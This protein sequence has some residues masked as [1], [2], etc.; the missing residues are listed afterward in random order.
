MQCNAMQFFR[1]HNF[2]HAFETCQIGFAC[3]MGFPHRKLMDPLLMM[4]FMLA[5]L[6]HDIDH[7]G[8]SNDF[9]VRTKD[10]LAILFHN[11]SVLENSY[12]WLGLGFERWWRV[13]VVVW[14]SDGRRGTGAGWCWVLGVG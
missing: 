5:S 3:L 6:G 12:S 11:R 7:P 4:A 8:Y 9:L 1:Y 10:P 2:H 13:V 14:A